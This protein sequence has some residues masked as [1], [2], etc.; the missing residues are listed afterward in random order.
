MAGRAL[1]SAGEERN[2]P[3]AVNRIQVRCGLKTDS[4][5]GGGIRVYKVDRMLFGQVSCGHVFAHKFRS[6]GQGLEVL[7]RLRLIPRINGNCS[8]MAAQAQVA[9]R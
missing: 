1:H 3:V 2:V 7:S 5:R 8:I 4:G 9:H 6:L